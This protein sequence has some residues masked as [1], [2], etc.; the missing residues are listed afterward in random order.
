MPINHLPRRQIEP[1][2]DPR[3]PDSPE[4]E[5]RSEIADRV[6]QFPLPHRRSWNSDDP[7]DPEEGDIEHVEWN[8]GPNLTFSRT[9][10]SSTAGFRSSTAGLSPAGYRGDDSSRSFFPNFS[11]IRQGTERQGGLP[12]RQNRSSR[13]SFRTSDRER[14]N[15]FPEDF[16][17]PWGSRDYNAGQNR[18]S[19]LSSRTPDRERPNAIPEDYI[20]PWGSG[21]YNTGPNNPREGIPG[22]GLPGSRYTGRSTFTARTRNWPQESGGGQLPQPSETNLHGQGTLST[23]L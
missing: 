16:N 21:D 8:A 10:R 23:P 9:Y 12:N 11:P 22:Q 17:L 7:P 18:S 19:R 5:D 6:S 1:D 15:P 3:N 4:S 20:L 14:P 13:L 2:H